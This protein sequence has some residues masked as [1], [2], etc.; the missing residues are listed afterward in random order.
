MRRA[1]PEDPGPENPGP[2]HSRLACPQSEN[3][4]PVDTQPYAHPPPLAAD[5]AE[6]GDAGD[7]APLPFLR[8]C[9]VS[10]AFGR[11]RAVTDFSLDIHRRELIALLGPSG[12]GKTTLMRMIAGLETPD[13]GR[14]EMDGT[15]ITSM[16]PH[17]RPFNMMFQSYALFPQLSV[18]ENVAF[19]LRRAGQGRAEIRA[20]VEEMLAL[21]QIEDLARRKPHEISGGQSQRVALARALARSPRLVLLDEPLA[22]LD[23]KLRQETQ[24]E[25][26]AIQEATDTTFLIVTHDREEAMTMAGRV[27][28]MNE[29][30]LI[31]IDA[32]QTIYERPASLD[33]ARLVGEINLIEGTISARSGDMVQ[34]ACGG[35]TVMLCGPPDGSLASGTSCVVAIRPEKIRL[36]KRRPAPGTNAL[37]GTLVNIAYLGNISTCRIALADSQEIRAQIFNHQRLQMH[38]FDCAEAVWLSFSADATMI[39]KRGMNV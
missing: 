30:R 26:M 10:K 37:R 28:V 29:G 5:A 38:E 4:T 24:I 31:Q 11:T 14:I 12:C 8:L 3:A 15:D 21:V 23:K 17:L 33:A 25:L 22:A 19:G 36:S 39:F 2:G 9:S 27:A 35:G 7:A 16:A 6:P 13:T 1:G 34:F 18:W 32:P 20:R